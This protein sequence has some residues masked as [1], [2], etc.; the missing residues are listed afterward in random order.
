M[1]DF[2][3]SVFGVLDEKMRKLWTNT[4]KDLIDDLQ[5]VV[6]KHHLSSEFHFVLE[7]DLKP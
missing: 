2:Y 4:F 7:K 1:V 5:V 6:D 3:R